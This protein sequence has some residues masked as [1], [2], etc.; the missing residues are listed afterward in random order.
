L[1]SASRSRCGFLELPG[2][3]EL[4][5]RGDR[6]DDVADAASDG[7]VDDPLDLV[8]EALQPRAERLDCLAAEVALVGEVDK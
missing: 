5:E 4:P 1:S 7:W 6:G 2:A 3:A 8:T